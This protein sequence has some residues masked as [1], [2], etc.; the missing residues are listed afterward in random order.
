MNDP[1]T[2]EW[3]IADEGDTSDAIDM[4]GYMLGGIDVPIFEATTAYLYFLHC[5]TVDGTY[6]PVYYDGARL[7]VA[8]DAVAARAIQVDPAKFTCQRFLKVVAVDSSGSA[9]TQ[10]SGPYTITPRCREYR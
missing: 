5:S 3:T 10:S 9:V 7:A 4:L 8:V 6:L 1:K 2:Q